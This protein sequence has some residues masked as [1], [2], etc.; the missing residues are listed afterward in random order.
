MDDQEKYRK[1]M[2]AATSL[3][4]LPDSAPTHDENGEEDWE[5]AITLNH[6]KA[7]QKVL[8]KQAMK[9]VWELY[10]DVHTRTRMGRW[11]PY[12]I[13]KLENFLFL[14]LLNAI[15][16]EEGAEED[17]DALEAVKDPNK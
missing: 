16:E 14:P 1:G 5:P 9:R 6:Q 11:D 3:R 10:K 15:A 8:Q 2:A 13:L 17:V 12:K 7:S 4:K